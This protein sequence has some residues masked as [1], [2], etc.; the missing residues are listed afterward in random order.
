[1]L[2]KSKQL[3]KS[4]CNKQ[5]KRNWV[6]RVLIYAPPFLKNGNLHELSVG[7]RILK[8]EHDLTEIEK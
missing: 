5:K 3:A 7:K 8:I 4:H 2:V 1:M 6:H